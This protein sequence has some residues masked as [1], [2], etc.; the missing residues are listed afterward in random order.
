MYSIY[1]MY[2]SNYKCMKYTVVRENSATEIRK[3]FIQHARY[4]YV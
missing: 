4:T 2:S 1:S 3:Y